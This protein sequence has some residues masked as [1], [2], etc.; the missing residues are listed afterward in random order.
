VFGVV[1]ASTHPTAMWATELLVLEPFVAVE[2][3][4]VAPVGGVLAEL[5]VAVEG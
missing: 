4:G 1:G 3:W 5:D 2:Y